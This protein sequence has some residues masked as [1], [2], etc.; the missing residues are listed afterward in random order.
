MLETPRGACLSLSIYIYKTSR[1]LNKYYIKDVIQLV[2]RTYNEQR[3][4]AKLDYK[5][6]KFE[7]EWHQM[8]L[9]F[10]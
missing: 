2:E 6:H 8:K 4:A 9:L 7:R 5:E 3:L 1:I 10:T